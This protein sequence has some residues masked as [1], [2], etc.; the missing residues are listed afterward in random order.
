MRNL[1]LFFVIDIMKLNSRREGK[2]GVDVAR[3]RAPWNY[4]EKSREWNAIKKSLSRNA[5]Y[6]IIRSTIFQMKL[7]T[8]WEKVSS[9]TVT[10][11]RKSSSFLSTTNHHV[12]LAPRKNKLSHR[13]PFLVLFAVDWKTF[14]LT[15]YATVNS[16]VNYTIS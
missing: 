4:I 16:S 12:L 13:S 8:G 15:F 3:R 14:M 1:I 11:S 7:N 6:F 9:A 5:F 2:Y 10:F